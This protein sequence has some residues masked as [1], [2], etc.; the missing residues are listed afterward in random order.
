MGRGVRQAEGAAEDVAELVV[1]AHRGRAEDAPAEP[2]PVQRLRAGLEVGAV[3]GQGRQCSGER[4]RTLLGHQRGDRRGVGRVQALDRVRERVHA[5][6]RRQLGRHRE[7]ERGVVDDG[8]RLDARLTAGALH[9]VLR[10]APDRRHLRAG[11][12][13]GHRDHR[14]CALERDGLAEPDG[15]AAADG[16]AAVGVDRC[17]H[18][19]GAA[20]DLDRHVH[21][22]FGQ[23]G[24]DPV[25]QEVRHAPAELL[26]GRAAD[27]H[28][29]GEPDRVDLLGELLQRADPEAHPYRLRA[30]DEGAGHESSR[31]R[32]TSK[33][34]TPSTT[35]R[36]R[37]SLTPKTASESRYGEPATKTC[38]VTG[39]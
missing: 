6:R 20:G 16:H 39:R 36:T 12:R 37:L 8:D 2:R 24:D 1:Q 17:G 19:A 5:A 15:R 26:V 32:P 11:V 3:G 21:P 23:H 28:H 27:H 14:K 35:S 18:L 29:A 13:R 30:V 22:G 25:A 31:S 34:R 10:Q 9:A 33:V 38:V 7:G 4:P